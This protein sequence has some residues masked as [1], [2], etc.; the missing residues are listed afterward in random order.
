MSELILYTSNQLETLAE[1]LAGQVRRPLR[2]PLD[3]EIVLVQ[4]Q[5]MSRWLKLQ[6]AGKHG[7]CSNCH[8]PFPRAFCLEVFKTVIG[9]LPAEGGYDPEVLRWR[10]MKALPGFL[11]EPEF[12]QVQ[13]YFGTGRDE[14]KLYQL[15]DRI[16]NVFDQYLVFRPE[17]I[18]EWE[19]GKGRDWQALLWRAVSGP[20][21]E[22]HPA[23]IQSR[24][25]RLLEESGGGLPGLPERVSIFGVSALP[26]FYLNIF[27]A[28][29][30]H[31]E[32][33]LYLLQPCEQYWGCISTPGEQEKT[34]KRAGKGA[35]E[36]AHLH[37]ESGNPL[38]A[39]MGKLG[40]DF[41]NLLLDSG[42]WLEPEPSL[43]A[44]NNDKHL[45]SS[46]QN[47]I[48]QLN[49]AEDGE[50]VKGKITLEDDS[51]Q[52]HSCHSPLREL[53][54][55]QDHLL[56]WFNRDPELTPRDVL[57]MIPKIEEYAPYIQ[58]VF[59][60]PDKE[61]HRIPFSLADRAAKSQ[62][63][64][65]DTFLLLLNLA[66]SRLGAS[67][68]LSVL[69]SAP[70]CRKFALDEEA[71]DRVRQW[72][73]KVRIRWG[74][75]GEHRAGLGLPTWPE[76]TW[77]HGLDRLLMGYAL[78][79]DDK[80]LFADILPYDDIEGN[81]SEVLGRFADFIDSLFATLDELK[82]NRPLKEWATT[83][84]RT[85][86]R[87]FEISETETQELQVLNG[88]FEQLTHAASQA[89]LEQPIGLAVVLEQLSRSLSEDVF[90]TGY[91][92]GKVTFCALKPM[93]SIPS[94][95]ICLLGI[96]D[97]S[98]PRTTPLLSFDL[99]Q[100]KPRPGDRSSRDD[101]RY[102]FLETLI[103]ARERLYVS[104]VGQSIK[105]NSEA[106]PSV[107]VSEL[108]D[109]VAEHYELEDPTQTLTDRILTRHRLQAF[110]QAYFQ[111]GRLFSYSQENLKASQVR[112]DASV[113]FMP[114]PL[115]AADQ[116]WRQV[117][118]HGLQSFWGN[119]AEYLARERMEIYMPRI[120]AA[121][122]DREAF[123][124]PGLEKYSLQQE[125][126]ELK[127]S[128]QCPKNAIQLMNAAGRLPAGNPGEVHFAR[129]LQEVENYY[130][131]LKPH[132]PQTRL[133]AIPVNLEIGSFVL[134][135]S[136]SPATPRRLLSYRMAKI[137][138]KDRLEAWLEHLVFCAMHNQPGAGVTTVIV[139]TD[140]T[141]RFDPVL[142]PLPLLESLLECY[143]KGLAQP[144]K[145]FLKTS[146]AFANASAKDVSGQTS[147]KARSAALKEWEGDE[148]R[149]IDGEGS[150]QY[151]AQ[152]FKSAAALDEDFE[153]LSNRV[154][155]P[156]LQH[157]R[158]E[159]L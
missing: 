140:L 16:A 44:P 135:G 29:A 159:T 154:F 54:V 137:K 18:Q 102:L 4:S 67:Q 151:I 150:D 48:L 94:K 105:D 61:S 87:L 68:V 20:F 31:V 152:F 120:S 107:L 58:A 133:S 5:G 95:V 104:F 28:L 41:L 99:M 10:I 49:G 23:A 86:S 90:G 77:R 71:L 124:I 155:H 158:E 109:Y 89:G 17:L 38:L 113:D 52:V 3:P 125:L 69:E 43:F 74:R 97:Q 118:L 129:I 144:L 40:R 33:G 101:D 59:G 100:Q 60:S 115:A 156:M 78:P 108:L 36:G 136:L 56:D 30:R 88:C 111:G 79:G 66:D 92:T 145:F 126:L 12:A 83:F 26:P 65:I 35:S 96:N 15:S 127:L 117:T 34:L 14:R 84:Q 148:F 7:I 45:L 13:H 64:L 57:V 157:S 147:D 98:F 112:R 119:P 47:D 73:G 75:D 131:R 93:R 114:E 143:W 9:E 63:H 132:L 80:A 142:E 82:A 81:S 76:N 72:I 6:L 149:G 21:R 11:K 91:L 116:E 22:Q 138:P 62:S 70:V 51:V 24:L 123:E 1:T 2:S 130:E 103:S 55:L 110:S 42:D 134:S 50:K 39:S 139:G 122:E 128:G 32:V 153:I 121:M 8:F 106:P 85:L 25:I 53:E 141:V 19:S 27:A 46:I 37:L 146:F